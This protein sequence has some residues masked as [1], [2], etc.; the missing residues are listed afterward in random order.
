MNDVVQ[1][2]VDI[3]KSSYVAKSCSS[4]AV[5]AENKNRTELFAKI[6]QWADAQRW[7]VVSTVRYEDDLLIFIHK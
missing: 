3:Q 1:V 2:C 6:M 5:V 7:V 4:N